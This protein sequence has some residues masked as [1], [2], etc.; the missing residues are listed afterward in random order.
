MPLRWT[1]TPASLFAGFH[2]PIRVRIV[3]ES[4]DSCGNGPPAADPAVGFLIGGPTTAFR[5]R[6]F[7]G[8]PPACGRF[9]NDDACEPGTWDMNSATAF[10]A[11]ALYLASTLM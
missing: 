9:A 8:G 1:A 10:A 2:C 7:R 6:K 11:Y 3:V 5:L 4:G